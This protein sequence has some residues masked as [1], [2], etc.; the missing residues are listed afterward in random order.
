VAKMIPR[1]SF[2]ITLLRD[3]DMMTLMELPDGAAAF[4]VFVLLIVAGRERL[5]EGRASRVLDTDALRFDDQPRIVARLA[6]CSWEQV[7]RAV[8]LMGQV[9]SVNGGEPWV[10]RD[11]LGRIVIRSFFKFNTSDGYGGA[12]EG[13][14]RPPKNQDEFKSESSSG[15]LNPLESNLRESPS[16]LP[17][18][19]PVPFPVPESVPACAGGDSHTDRPPAG[20]DRPEEF[21][22]LADRVAL[23]WSDAASGFPAIVKGA[24]LNGAFLAAWNDPPMG[25]GVPLA[26]WLG[27]LDAY[28]HKRDD[29]SLPGLIAFA[30]NYRPPAGGVSRKRREWGEMT[31]DETAEMKAKYAQIEAEVEAEKARKRKA[32]AS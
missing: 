28:R 1:G 26:S 8:D 11:E 20:L 9:A 25:S 13:A 7:E 4:G 14:G 16:P 2:P 3:Q 31:P 10:G 18:P 22:Q 21:K 23:V 24:D 15:R 12:R 27:C 32:V 5:Q 6:L 19:S 29:W 30:R 17:L